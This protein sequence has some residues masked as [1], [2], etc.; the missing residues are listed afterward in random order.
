MIG[1]YNI[2]DM[3]DYTVSNAGTYEITDERIKTQFKGFVPTI[4]FSGV[5]SDKPILV[6]NLC[7]VRSGGAFM[8][9]SNFGYWCSTYTGNL[10]ALNIPLYTYSTNVMSVSYVILEYTPNNGKLTITYKPA[11]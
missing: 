2:L 5:F 8:S 3:G 1:G 6:T 11:T 10:Y 4:K 9:V 7:A